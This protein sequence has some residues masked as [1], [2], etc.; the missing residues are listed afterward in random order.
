MVG[1]PSVFFNGINN[2]LSIGYGFLNGGKERIDN[3]R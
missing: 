2:P 3:V 1:Y